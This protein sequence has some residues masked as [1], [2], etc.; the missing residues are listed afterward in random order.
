MDLKQFDSTLKSALDNIEV[1]FDSSAWAAFENRLDAI[2][3]PDAVDKVVRPTLERFEIPYDAGSWA[4]LANRMDGIARVRRL[5]MTKL[6]ELAIFLLLLLNLQG[7]FGVVKSVTSPKPAAPVEAK[8][9]IAKARGHKAK[10]GTAAAENQAIAENPSLTEQVVA[11][12]QNIASTLGATEFSAPQE[13]L[14]NEQLQPLAAQK[15][16]LDPSNFYSQSGMVKFPVGPNLPGS[17]SQAIAF[18]NA[19]NIIIPGVEITQGK[20]SNRLYAAT[21]GAFDVNYF[22]EEEFKNKQN[23][24]GGGMAV[25]Y[26]KGKWGVE[27]GLKYTQ[28]SYQPKEVKETYINDPFNGIAFFFA[29]EVDA[30]VVEIPVK[31]TRRI[32]KMGKTSAHA[33]AGVTGHFAASKRYGYQTLHYPPPIP[34]G[35]PTTPPSAE[36]PVGNGVLEK[37]GLSNNAYATADLGL[38]V[39]QK[40]GKRY[41]AF[42]EPAF[43]QSLGGSFGPRASKLSTFSLQ[44]GV[45]ASL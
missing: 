32:A 37:G 9:P 17:P 13:G 10:K 2:P 11:F 38:R 45:M 5:R 36:F 6:A 41:V 4:T 15:S 23:G 27:A 22:Q 42:I 28:K 31:V 14:E 3:A 44:A 26:R 12:V 19:K 16:V 40:I 21:F 35:N 34:V 18:A 30:D 1:P 8:Q 39:E 25:G 20:H 33:V 29:D 24:F 43:R 7:F